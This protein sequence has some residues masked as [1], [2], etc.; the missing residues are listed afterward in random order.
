MDDEWSNNAGTKYWVVG[1]GSNVERLNQ[2][3][4]GNEILKD[5][6]NVSVVSTSTNHVYVNMDE[7]PVADRPI[8]TQLK[9]KAPFYLVDEGL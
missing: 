5:G 2:W 1:S 7:T 3:D 8:Y 4:G 6:G 9:Q